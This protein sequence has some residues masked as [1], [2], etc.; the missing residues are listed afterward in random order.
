[1]DIKL[2]IEAIVQQTINATMNE[3]L[4][5]VMPSADEKTT[6][7]MRKFFASLNERGVSTQTIIECFA[8]AAKE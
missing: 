4:F 8:E 7:M 1:M 5:S 3:V 6:R 2:N